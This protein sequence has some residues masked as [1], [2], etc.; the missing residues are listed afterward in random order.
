MIDNLVPATAV[1]LE[2]REFGSYEHEDKDD[3]GWVDEGRVLPA[4]NQQ[5]TIDRPQPDHRVL[6]ETTGSSGSS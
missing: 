1:G 5:G 2:A 3:I 4:L 6:G